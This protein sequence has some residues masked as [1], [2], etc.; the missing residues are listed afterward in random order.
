MEFEIKKLNSPGWLFYLLLL[1][2]ITSCSKDDEA[3]I[4]VKA[5][6]R[7]YVITARID[8]KQA[9][10]DSQATGILTGTYS[11]KT[12]LFTYKLDY[13]NLSPT[14]ISINKGVR[15]AAGVE[16]I[17]LMR[18]E[19]LPF[20]APIAG[21]KLLSSLEERDLIRGFWF[22]TIGSVTYSDC[23][24]RGQVTLKQK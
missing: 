11:E 10:T 4:K 15:G 18:P 23:E 19:G 9:G 22:V 8:N 2:T 6:L 5:P 3:Q 1:L 21:K 12:K 7:N 13:D 20:S 24:I 16:V 17:R 14:S